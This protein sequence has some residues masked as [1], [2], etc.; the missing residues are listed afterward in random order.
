LRR[1][2]YRPY[3]L[4]GMHRS[5]GEGH[6]RGRLGQGFHGAIFRHQTNKTRKQICRFAGVLR[7]LSKRPSL[8]VGPGQQILAARRSCWAAPPER[9][10]FPAFLAVETC[11]KFASLAT[12]GCNCVCGL[13]GQVRGRQAMRNAC[14]WSWALHAEGRHKSFTAGAG[15]LEWPKTQSKGARTAQQ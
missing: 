8:S 6:G 14:M 9:G 1:L 15:G 4:M 13:C 10:E 3:R 5:Y 11:G 2:V 12:P 7:A